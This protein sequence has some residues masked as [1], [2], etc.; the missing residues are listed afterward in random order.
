[1]HPASVVLLSNESATGGSKPWPGGRG[2]FSVA[3]TFGG[4][5]ATLEMLGPD[6]ATWFAVG[7]DTTKTQAGAGNFDLPP[8]LLRVALTG[9]TPSGMYARA[10]R[11]PA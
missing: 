2:T 7:T 1:M 6:G 11:V 8:C 3:G 4:A 10:D 9:G 5:T